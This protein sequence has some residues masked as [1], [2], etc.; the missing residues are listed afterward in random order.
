[1]NTEAKKEFI[2]RKIAEFQQVQ[3]DESS[4]HEPAGEKPTQEEPQDDNIASEDELTQDES[5]P[6]EPRW[7]FEVIQLKCH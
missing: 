3:P 5:E 1:M 2:A 4:P 6:E 7:K